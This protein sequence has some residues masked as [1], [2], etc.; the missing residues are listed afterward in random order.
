MRFVSVF[1]LLLLSCVGMGAES[2]H[3]LT[4]MLMTSGGQFG[5]NSSGYMPAVDMALEDINNDSS[6][7]PGYYLMYDRL[8]DSKVRSHGLHQLTLHTHRDYRL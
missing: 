2:R 6:I 3:N 4:F 5:F 1:Q 8:R 7:L